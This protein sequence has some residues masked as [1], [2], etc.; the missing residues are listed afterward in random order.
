MLCRPVLIKQLLLEFP[1]SRH[2]SSEWSEQVTTF[3]SFSFLLT[4]VS[5]I[6]FSFYIA[7]NKK[8]VVFIFRSVITLFC[9]RTNFIRTVRL[10]LIKKWIKI[11]RL[12]SLKPKINIKMISISLKFT[13]IRMALTP[14]KSSYFCNVIRCSI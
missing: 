9:I 4:A 12:G 3:G 5:Q 10:K 14:S 13:Y 8:T 1:T 6:F 2:F 11:L 7:S